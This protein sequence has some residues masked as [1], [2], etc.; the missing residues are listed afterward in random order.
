MFS[1]NSSSKYTPSY[2]RMAK[3]IDQKLN[4]VHLSYIE[5]PEYSNLVETFNK[6]RDWKSQAKKVF[7]FC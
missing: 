5:C 6:C 1:K 3:L 4:S 7:F 2:D